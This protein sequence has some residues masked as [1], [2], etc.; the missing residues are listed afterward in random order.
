MPL[1]RKNPKRPCLA[2]RLQKRL[3]RMKRTAYPTAPSWYVARMVQL[4]RFLRTYFPVSP[5]ASLRNPYKTRKEK[6]N[7]AR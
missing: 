1:S 3:R 7:H 4:Q 6:P 2:K 5:I